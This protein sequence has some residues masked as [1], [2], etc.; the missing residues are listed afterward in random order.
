MSLT[1]LPINVTCH[2]SMTNIKEQSTAKMQSNSVT[3]PERTSL[4]LP[5]LTPRTYA[6]PWGLLLAFYWRLLNDKISEFDDDI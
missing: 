1:N 2:T 3:S 4:L 5:L 6:K